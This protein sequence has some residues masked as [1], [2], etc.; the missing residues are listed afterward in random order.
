ME[1]LTI[2]GFA[3]TL[4]S[5]PYGPLGDAPPPVY[6]VASPNRDAPSAFMQP[7]DRLMNT[8]SAAPHTWLHGE[9]LPLFRV[10][11]LFASPLAAPTAFIHL[12]NPH[13]IAR[14]NSLVSISCTLNPLEEEYLHTLLLTP[15]MAQNAL[16]PPVSV[17]PQPRPTYIPPWP[18]AQ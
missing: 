10:P 9:G 3:P 5:T 17:A 12:P 1:H 14:D 15:Q 11:Y 16:Q 8:R 6:P 4:A 2:S 13:P 7:L 18:P